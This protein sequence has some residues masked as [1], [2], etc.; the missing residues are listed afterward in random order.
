MIFFYLSPSF[1]IF[2]LIFPIFCM[3]FPFFFPFS[4][5]L[6]HPPYTFFAGLGGGSKPHNPPPPCASTP[7]EFYWYIHKSFNLSWGYR[8]KLAQISKAQWMPGSGL[9]GKKLKS[10]SQFSAK[11][12]KGFPKLWYPRLSNALSSFFLIWIWSER[13]SQLIG[14][15]SLV[16]QPS[17]ART[18]WSEQGTGVPPCVPIAR[19]FVIIPAVNLRFR[20]RWD[21]LIFLPFHSGRLSL[22]DQDPGRTWTRDRA[23]RSENLPLDQDAIMIL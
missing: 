2:S 16:W 22:P 20:P 1:S 10:S 14:T 4:L 7:M 5:S 18:R 15:I 19:D 3:I 12:Q 13:I 11:E 21:V 9:S 6:L 23:M 17:R 8:L